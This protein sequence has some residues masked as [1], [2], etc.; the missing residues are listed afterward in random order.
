MDL[1]GS[2]WR[3]N[4]G[5]NAV[6]RRLVEVCG[7]LWRMKWWPGR[8]LNPRHADFQSAA[9]PTELPGLAERRIKQASAAIVNEESR[10]SIAYERSAP[11][12]ESNKAG[13]G[14][15]LGGFLATVSRRPLKLPVQSR[16]CDILLQLMLECRCFDGPTLAASLARKHRVAKRA[17]ALLLGIFVPGQIG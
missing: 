13:A 3:K 12:S 8:E 5:K 1:T 10:N 9:L 7:S 4:P 15:Q 17:S 11:R 14:R 2:K 6:F 16:S